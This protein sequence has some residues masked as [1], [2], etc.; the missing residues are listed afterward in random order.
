VVCDEIAKLP[1]NIAGAEVARAKAQLKAGVLMSRESSAAR[2][3]QLAQQ[4]LTYG[5]P[6]P[7]AEIVA[8]I[9]AV[10]AEELQRLA[11]T[12]FR[13]RPTIAALGPIG[14]VETYDRLAARLE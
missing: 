2:C 5:R 1:R 9:D 12:L 11:G 10:E 6:L 4:L 8:K 3:D 14:R 7:V 13:S